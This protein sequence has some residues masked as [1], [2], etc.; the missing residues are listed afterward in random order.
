MQSVLMKRLQIRTVRGP[1]TGRSSLRSS[2]YV[3]IAIRSA[4]HSKPLDDVP[5]Q[6]QHRGSRIDNRLDA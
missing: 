4:I 5:R 2:A 1:A 3:T 6:N